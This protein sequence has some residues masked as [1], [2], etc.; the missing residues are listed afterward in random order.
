MKRRDEVMVGV[1]ITA[2]LIVLVLGTLWLARRGLGTRTYPLHTSFAWGA[3]LKQGQQ[4]LLAGVQVGYVDEVRLRR[5]GF[6]D[7][8]MQIER[9]YTVPEGTVA[10]VQQVSFFGDKAV[11]LVPSR[12]TLQSVPPGDTLPAGKPAP[13]MDEIMARLDTVATSVTDVAQAFEFEMVKGGGIADLRRTIGSTNALVGRLNAVAAE[14][15][16]ALSATLGTLRRTVSAIDS[17]QLDSTVRNLQTTTANLATLTDNLTTTSTR[18]NTLLAKVDSGTGT[19]GRLLN[20]PGLY[21]DLRRLVTRLDSL[22]ADFKKNPRRY[23]NLE[24]F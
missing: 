5:E 10:T 14:Q 23:I 15:S 11:A 13:S 24:I 4:V 3:G 7:V 18:L 9:E 19:A 21:N 16:R 1:F 22:S 6:L 20:D 2:A 12:F 8:T 17:T